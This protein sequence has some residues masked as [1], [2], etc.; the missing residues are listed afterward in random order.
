MHFCRLEE[1]DYFWFSLWLTLGPM[2]PLEHK[3][4]RRP[5]E[6]GS[7]FSQELQGGWFAHYNFKSIGQGSCAKMKLSRSTPKI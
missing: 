2:Y 4:Q 6:L 5:T 7:A 1:S 3:H